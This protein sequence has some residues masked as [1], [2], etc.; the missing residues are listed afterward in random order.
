MIRIRGASGLG[1][2]VYLRAVAEHFARQGERVI[3]CSNFPEIFKGSP[4]ETEPF[5]RTDVDRVAHYVTGKTRRGTTQWQDVCIAA[6]AIGEVPFRFDW[7][8]GPRG[9]VERVR[10]MAGDLPVV[11]V[12]GGRVPMNRTDGFGSKIM[13]A[14]EPFARA[15]GRV[16]ADCYLVAVGR[17]IDRVYTLPCDLDLTDATTVPDLLDLF[18][19]A[20]GVVG[21]CSFAVPMAEVFDRPLLAIW[22]S[23]GLEDREPYVRQITP[24]KVL[25]KPSSR[26]VVDD[27][28]AEEII[29]A[30]A[31]FARHVTKGAK[32][33]SS[34]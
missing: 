3:A 26:H 7:T 17:R 13:P 6:G 27:V 33:A 9:W 31:A 5:R 21:Q 23:E 30:A 1:D 28:P 18:Q 12:H 20:D 24:E 34:T 25:S 29:A 32:C 14:R 2:S 22:S 4:V 15:L 11:L 8:R 19:D 16:G 10:E